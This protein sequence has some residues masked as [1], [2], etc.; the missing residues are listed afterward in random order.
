MPTKPKGEDAVE[1]VNVGTIE[2]EVAIDQALTVRFGIVEVARLL[3]CKSP[4]L[5]MTES[6]M[7]SPSVV[8]FST[9]RVEAVVE[10]RVCPPI[11]VRELANM[12]PSASTKNLEESPTA[13]AIST[14][15]APAD[16]GFTRNDDLSIEEG[17]SPTAHVAKE[18][19]AV[20]ALVSKKSTATVDV[21]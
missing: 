20:G 16:A 17:A 7:A 14:V 2:V 1:I 8:L 12:S 10:E 11:D 3:N 19:A 13:A 4:E 18:W 5:N 15:S 6:P 21:S 9:S